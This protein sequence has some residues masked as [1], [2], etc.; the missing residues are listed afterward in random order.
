MTSTISCAT[1]PGVL[2]LHQLREDAFEIG[3]AHQFREIGG[4]R[5]GQNLLPLAMT[6]TRLQTCST[7]S[8]TCE[9]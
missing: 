3:K 6:M 2:L 1:A 5:V 8:S 7:T 4:R 9:M